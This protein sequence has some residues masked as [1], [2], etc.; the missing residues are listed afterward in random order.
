M[1]RKYALSRY[2]NSLITLFFIQRFIQGNNKTM[3]K[4]LHYWLFVDPPHKGLIMQKAFPCHGLITTG[5]LVDL[6][7]YNC[8]Q[9]HVCISEQCHH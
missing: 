1:L 8:K 6:D 7:A 5:A 4:A 9:M 3:I 2:P